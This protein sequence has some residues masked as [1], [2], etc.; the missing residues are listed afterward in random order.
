[1]S[2]R[3]RLSLELQTGVNLTIELAEAA[4]ELN[5]LGIK[6]FGQGQLFSCV[7][8]LP[9]DQAALASR[10]SASGCALRQEKETPA[11]LWL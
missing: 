10:T 2:S 8:A 6:S 11:V 3:H 1:M 7:E 9:P 4:T 5:R